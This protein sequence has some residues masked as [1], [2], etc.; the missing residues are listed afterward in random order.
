[1]CDEFPTASIHRF[2]RGVMNKKIIE[3][4]FVKI[5]SHTILKESKFLLFFISSN[6]KIFKEKREKDTSLL[7]KMANIFGNDI[8]MRKKHLEIGNETNNMLIL[9]EDERK[10]LK[11]FLEKLKLLT[12]NNVE[13]YEAAVSSAG[14]ISIL[15]DSLHEEIFSLA[16]HLG[17]LTES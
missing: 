3:Q 1:M 6:D 16:D 15:L 17:K 10:R 5:L 4:F 2:D 11:V 7:S 8:N 9:G 14:K 13:I 12:T